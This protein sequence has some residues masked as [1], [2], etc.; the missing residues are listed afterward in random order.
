MRCATS[1]R[2]RIITVSSGGFCFVLRKQLSNYLRK[3]GGCGDSD[4]LE[5]RALSQASC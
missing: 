1:L 3:N 5:V 2:R 4:I